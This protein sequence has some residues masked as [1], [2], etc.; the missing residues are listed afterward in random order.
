M[1]EV[2]AVSVLQKQASV[3]LEQK[4]EETINATVLEKSSNEKTDPESSSS[5]IQV[6]MNESLIILNSILNFMFSL[7]KKE[8][9]EKSP[10]KSN[11]TLI[12]L[13]PLPEKS[14]HENT[15]TTTLL[16]IR[17]FSIKL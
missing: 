12:S 8:F 13:D 3:V 9:Q 4:L 10:K 6:T 1:S 5:T 11:G 17:Y 14:N 2:S 16:S 15:I 7:E